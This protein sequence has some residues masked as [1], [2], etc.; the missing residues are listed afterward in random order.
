MPVLP[1]PEIVKFLGLE[2]EIDIHN[3]TQGEM[4]AILRYYYS[5]GDS[6]DEH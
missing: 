2:G 6:D 1:F 5:L 4:I 3:L